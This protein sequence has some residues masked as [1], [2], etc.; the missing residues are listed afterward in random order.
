MIFILF[1]FAMSF[2]YSVDYMRDEKEKNRKKGEKKEESAQ[3]YTPA[4]RFGFDCVFTHFGYIAYWTY[5]A[6]CSFCF[7]SSRTW[8]LVLWDGH[9]LGCDF[10][11]RACWIGMVGLRNISYGFCR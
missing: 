10:C 2:S 6:H 8:R 5:P 9:G 3:L 11:L 7:V 4:L 1:Q